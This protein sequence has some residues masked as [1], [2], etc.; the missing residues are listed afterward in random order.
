MRGEFESLR[1]EGLSVVHYDAMTDR[2]SSLFED[3]LVGF[4]LVFIR[5]K[6]KKLWRWEGCGTCVLYSWRIFLPGFF[7]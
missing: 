7:F 1:V 3:D 5:R 4:D 6:T 2:A